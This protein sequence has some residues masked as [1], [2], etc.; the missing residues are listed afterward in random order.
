MRHCPAPVGAA[1]VFVADF[2][3]FGPVRNPPNNFYFLH[4]IGGPREK[5]QKPVNPLQNISLHFL[6]AIPFLNVDQIF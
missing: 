6:I 2:G 4:F 5:N 1:F 3:T